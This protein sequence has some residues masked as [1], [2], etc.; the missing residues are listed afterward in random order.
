MAKRP[1]TEWTEP[2][3]DTH[4]RGG[5]DPTLTTP[6]SIPPVHV[7]EAAYDQERKEAEE[8]LAGFD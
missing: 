1:E 3:E 6:E 8:L 7:L 2:V 4:A 5:A